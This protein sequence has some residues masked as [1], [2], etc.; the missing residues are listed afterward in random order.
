M[1]GALAMLLVLIAPSSSGQQDPDGVIAIEGR[2]W[3][4]DVGDAA[5]PWRDADEFCDGLDAGGFTDWRLPS[6]EELLSLHAPDAPGGIEGPFELPDCCAWSSENL[7]VRPTDRKGALPEP[8][9]PAEGYYWGFLFDGGISYYS[10]GRFP[11]G[12]ALCTRD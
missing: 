5:S 1:G 7:V 12:F 11:D 10:N 2:I 4:L 3:S 8:G 9:G 6:L